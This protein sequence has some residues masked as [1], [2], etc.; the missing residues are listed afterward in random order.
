MRILTSL[1]AI[2]IALPTIALAHSPTTK[3]IRAVV[4][5][6]DP[7]HALQNIRYSLP[8]GPPFEEAESSP[9][10]PPLNT[11][12]P[13]TPGTN[14]VEVNF[15]TDCDSA[16]GSR[17][18]QTGIDIAVGIGENLQV[19]VS[20]Y[21]VEERVSG[22]PTFRGTGVTNLGAKYR[23]YDKNGLQ[24]ATYPNYQFDDG[25]RHLNEDGT[26]AETEG[27][28]VY[29]PIIVSKELGKWTVVSNVGYSMNLKSKDRN[30]VFTSV[31]LGRSLSQ[32]SRVMTEV[33]A[34]TS[35]AGTTSDVRVGWVKVI[36]P[37]EESRFRTAFFVSAGKSLK[38]DDGLS[39]KT[40]RIGLSIALKP[41]Q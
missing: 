21:A 38:S 29:L 33:T 22:E 30:S 13:G 10:S 7:Q 11:D 18:C 20:K 25:T 14:G 19:R 37:N 3:K 40:L 34:S 35:K 28:A 26:P 16:K 6:D 24:I 4:I 39:H 23:F 41:K 31:A 32:T 9:S 5:L 17:S 8:P 27:S 36:F 2:T 12:D 1:I 15:V